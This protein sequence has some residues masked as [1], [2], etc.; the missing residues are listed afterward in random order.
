MSMSEF[1]VVLVIAIIMIKPS[2]IP[3]MMKYIRSLFQYIRQ[4]QKDIMTY[5][6]D[7]DDIEEINKYLSKISEFDKK[8]DGEYNNEKVVFTKDGFGSAFHAC[9]DYKLNEH[10]DLFGEYS[11][12]DIGLL[13][14]HRLAVGIKHYVY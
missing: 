11:Y 4:I 6:D 13:N 3:Q 2:D 5:F 8:Y 14:Y 9:V 7:I 10:I 1:L 12:A